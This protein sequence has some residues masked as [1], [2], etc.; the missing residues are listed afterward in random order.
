M[1]LSL[2]KERVVMAVHR[3]LA[4]VLLVAAVSAALAGAVPAGAAGSAPQ[5]ALTKTVN[6]GNNSTAP[7]GVPYQGIAVDPTTHTVYKT[8]SRSG[9][10][11]VINGVTGAIESRVQ[12]GGSLLGVA[13]DPTA[14]RVYTANYGASNVSEV[15]TQTNKVVRVFQGFPNGPSS[16]AVN[17]KTHLLYVASRTQE[18]VSIYDP[19]TGAFVKQLSGVSGPVAVDPGLRRFYV[20]SHNRLLVYNAVTNA[21][22]MSVPMPSASWNLAVDLASHDVYVTDAAANQANNNNVRL[23]LMGPNFVTRSVTGT[24]ALGAA[25]DPTGITGFVNGYDYLD[26]LTGG[27]GATEQHIGLPGAGG[28]A[29]S[30]AVDPTNH[31]VYVDK[32]NRV[33]FYGPK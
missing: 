33:L 8:D 30:I 4:P 7:L 3:I 6:L 21:L 29:I 18:A 27:T 17:P 10:L 13:V 14:N 28:P 9:Q 20:L 19:M 11:F 31:V 24:D 25:V 1:L 12:I 23:T 22:L 32:T 15:D 5:Y 2:C 26:V 16:I